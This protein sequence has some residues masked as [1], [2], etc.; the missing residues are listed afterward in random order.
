MSFS[1][2]R[3][4]V[5]DMDGEMIGRIMVILMSIII[6]AILSE[7]AFQWFGK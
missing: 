2:K 5:S 1:E 3:K 7:I 4:A 6:G